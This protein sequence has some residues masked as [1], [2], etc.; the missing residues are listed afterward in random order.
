M[1]RPVQWERM[2]P[3]QLENAFA[4]CPVLYLP[5]GR[6]LRLPNQLREHLLGTIPTVLLTQAIAGVIFLTLSISFLGPK[7]RCSVNSPVCS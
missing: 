4:E 3:D 6:G 1:D 5:Y 2:F 7:W